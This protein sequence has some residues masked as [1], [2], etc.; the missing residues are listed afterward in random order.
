MDLEQLPVEDLAEKTRACLARSPSSS[1]FH[2]GLAIRFA[3]YTGSYRWFQKGTGL[4]IRFVT[5]LAQMS[6]M[7]LRLVW[8]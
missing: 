4:W 3:R 6:Q 2:A 1:C 7:C 5:D 8:A